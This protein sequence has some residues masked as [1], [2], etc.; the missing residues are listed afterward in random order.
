MSGLEQDAYQM[1]EVYSEGVA[2]KLIWACHD[3]TGAP[4]DEITSNVGFS[5]YKFLGKYEFNKVSS[6]KT[7]RRVRRS[8]G[9]SG[10]P[11]RNS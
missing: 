2:H 3:V 9:Y 8:C 1:D 11:S 6:T 5:F 7:K 10:A 4:I